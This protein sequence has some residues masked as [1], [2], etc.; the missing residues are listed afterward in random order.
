MLKFLTVFST[1]YEIHHWNKIVVLL[2]SF[3]NSYSS[4]KL[5]SVIEENIYL[6]I[7]PGISRLKCNIAVHTKEKQL[8]VEN[9]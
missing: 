9:F 3:Y 4:N 2:K 5:V 8:K 7:K 6:K 1:S